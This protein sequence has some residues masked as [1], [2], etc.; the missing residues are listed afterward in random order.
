MIA[1]LLQTIKHIPEKDLDCLIRLIR[2]PAK[3]DDVALL[4]HRHFKELQSKGKLPNTEFDHSDIISF[5]LQG[6]CGH[7]K[8]RPQPSGASSCV[9]EDSAVLDGS[10]SGSESVNVSSPIA[11]ASESFDDEHYP[12]SHSSM[13]HGSVPM[14]DME[15]FS[16]SQMFELAVEDRQD[17]HVMDKLPI[18]G[19]GPYAPAY[20][21]PSLQVHGAVPQRYGDLYQGLRAQSFAMFPS[22]AS[23]IEHYLSHGQ[24]GM[25]ATVNPHIVSGM[26][27]HGEDFHRQMW[28]EYELKSNA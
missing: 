23:P 9:L 13:A 14:L 2:R 1:A 25:L 3:P 19:H 22:N 21:Q 12:V 28:P 11:S 20:S 7:R 16:S 18:Y 15:G 10:E 24:G 6:L 5:G 26:P 27:Q 17:R 4:L 8:G